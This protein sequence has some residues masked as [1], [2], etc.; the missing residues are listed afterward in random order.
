[1]CG[2]GWVGG[3]GVTAGT[4]QAQVLVGGAEQ[5]VLIQPKERKW[6]NCSSGLCSLGT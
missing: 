6:G 2:G 5:V 1:M 3:G 4:A